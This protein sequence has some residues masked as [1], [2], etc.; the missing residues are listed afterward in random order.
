VTRYGN[1]P[2]R[3]FKISEDPGETKDLAAQYPERVEALVKSAE[4]WSRSHVEPLWFH[5][6]EARDS[7]S[8]N[9]MPHFDQTF[10]PDIGA[11]ALPPVKYIVDEPAPAAAMAAPP[12]VKLKKGDSTKAMFFAQEKVKWDKNGWNWNPAK[13]ESLFNEIDTNH[14]GIASGQEKKIY[15]SR[16]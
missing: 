1:Q 5:A 15:W 16:Q 10:K 9:Q 2:W 11:P 8:K 7:W 12:G 14:D 13:V 4:K 6:G 3:L